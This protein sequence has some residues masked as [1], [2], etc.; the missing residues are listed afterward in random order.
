MII[1]LGEP[2]F[3]FS[4]LVVPLCKLHWPTRDSYRLFHRKVISV[5]DQ[6]Y[7]AS[8]ICNHI[9]IR[10]APLVQIFQSRLKT[11]YLNRLLINSSWTCT[12][13]DMP[14]ISD[15]NIMLKHNTKLCGRASNNNNDIKN[16]NIILVLT[17]QQEYIKAMFIFGQMICF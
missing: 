12:H 6:Y 15:S 4:Q 1:E 9:H 17:L 14:E 5:P 8:S 7:S 3:L 13:T 16:N 2:L 11:W 10:V